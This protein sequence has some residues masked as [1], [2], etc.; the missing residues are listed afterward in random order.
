M[1]VLFFSAISFM[2]TISFLQS[3]FIHECPKQCFRYGQSNVRNEFDLIHLKLYCSRVLLFLSLSFN[4]HN[5]KWCPMADVTAYT[6]WNNFTTFRNFEHI[7][8]NLFLTLFSSAFQFE[9]LQSNSV[10]LIWYLKWMIDDLSQLNHKLIVMPLIL[11]TMS[12][13]LFHSLL[14]PTDI[15]KMF[16]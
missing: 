5:G 1:L 16:L 12:N 11:C 10:S 3:N 14:Q 8:C 4:L 15:E 13:I 9:H 6:T 2:P 7:F